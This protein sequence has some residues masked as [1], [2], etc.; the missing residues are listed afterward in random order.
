[1]NILRNVLFY[2][3]IFSLAFHSPA[4]LA[5]FKTMPT[6]IELEENLWFCPQTPQD[7]T[8]LNLK[9]QDQSQ[10]ENKRISHRGAYEARTYTGERS[11]D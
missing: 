1:M 8:D 7:Y 9:Q 10:T 2:T 3:C 11:T 5:T 6:E 4:R